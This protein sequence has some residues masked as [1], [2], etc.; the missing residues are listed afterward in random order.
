M[1]DL[2][3]A[4]DTVAYLD[5]E[6]RK[7]EYETRQRIERMTGL[8]GD[9]DLV[10]RQEWGK[11]NEQVLPMREQREHLARAITTIASMTAPPPMLLTKDEAEERKLRR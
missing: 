11:F 8:D 3:Q 10:S 5:L 6:I 1:N 4:R 9:N 2:D 7:L